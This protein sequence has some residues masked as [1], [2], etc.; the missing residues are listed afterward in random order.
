VREVLGEETVSERRACQVLGQARSTQRRARQV[1]DDEEFLTRRIIEIAS[2]Y[3]RYGYRRVTGMLVNE[4]FRVNHKRVERIWR[5]EGLKVPKRQ[6]KRGRLWLNDGSCIRLRPEHRNHVWS[7]DFMAARTSNGRPL[8][9]LNIIDEYTRE[10]LSIRV[11]RN[12]TSEDVLEELYTLFM[13]RGAPEHL[14]SDNGSEFTAHKVRDWL[15]HV[16]VKT[17]FIEPGS[18]WENGYCESFNSKLRD[19]LLNPELFDTLLEARV[20]VERWRRYYNELRPHSALGYR[21][22]APAAWMIGDQQPGFSLW[23]PTGEMTEGRAKALPY[24]YGHL[25]GA[26][27]APLQSPILPAGSRECSTDGE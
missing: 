24:P 27:V 10:C 3:G 19:E 13:W 14:R 12:L 26:Q 17:A 7:Y 18:P 22:P 4:G 9:L 6:P 25:P 16:D 5:R 2:R 15:K 11:A 23:G 20:L 1:P 8:R 21:P